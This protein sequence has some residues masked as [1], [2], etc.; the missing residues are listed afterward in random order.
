V[1]QH[2]ALGFL[3]RHGLA[4]V[5][6]GFLVS[7]IALAF[8]YA[9]PTSVQTHMSLALFAL[10]GGA[11]A[12]ELPGQVKADVNLGTKLVVGATGAAAIFVILYFAVPA[13]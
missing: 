2:A 11:F 3:G 12:T 5:G 10:G 9:H 4:A 6:I 7:A 8:G 1:R 13:Q